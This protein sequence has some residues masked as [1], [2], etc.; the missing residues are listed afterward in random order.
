LNPKTGRFKHLSAA[1]GL[2]RGEMESALRDNAGNL[3]FASTQGLS[4]LAPVETRALLN[5]SVLI[6]G[7]QKG[8][9]AFPVSQTGETSISHLELE[10]SQ[11]QLQVEFVAFTGEPEANLR[12]AYKLEGTPSDWSPPRR[13]HV[14]NYDALASGKYRFLVKAVNSDGL[15]S[16]SPAAV[17]FTVLPPFWRRWWFEG[18]ALA[19]LASIV[20]LLHSYRVSHV[21]SLERMR[22]AIATD[23]HDDIGA[24]LSQI[25]ILSEV[26]RAGVRPEDRL[27]QESMQRV[28]SLARE[29]VDSMSDIVW[30]IRTE[31][32]G[33]DSLV[34]RMREFALDLLVSQGVDFELRTPQPLDHVRLSLQARRQL[35]LMFKECIHNVARH[36]GCTSVKAEL[37]AV[38]RE[39]V[40][41]V[42][43]NGRGWN[44]IESPSEEQPR[45]WPGGNG[46]PGMRRRAETLGGSVQFISKPGAGC[47][48]RVRLPARG[49]PLV[50]AR[51]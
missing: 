38:D 48:V 2:A 51:F 9:V 8:G 15:E 37:K 42:E 13:Q 4:R 1:D 41:T 36:S 20:Y 45:E 43:D 46:I 24:S 31:P 49:G 39:I 25:A 33:L 40:L 26:A 23:L 47:T 28:G 6:T 18:L 5:P 34:R 11:N 21:V 14:V 7:L 10:P 19:A 16:T 17:E 30:S 3:W 50:K 22:T 32:D 44:P 29:L 12:Y 35:F 27:P